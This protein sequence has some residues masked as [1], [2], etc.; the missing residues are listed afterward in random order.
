M[1][2]TSNQSARAYATAKTCK[3]SHAGRININGLKFKPITD[4]AGTMIL[5]ANY[6]KL[7]CKNSYHIQ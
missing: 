6:L 4:K 2:L 1:L 5:N 3:I 7:Y